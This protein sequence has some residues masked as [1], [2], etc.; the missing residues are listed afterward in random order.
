MTRDN[1]RQEKKK[2][3][4]AKKKK[5]IITSKVDA[6]CGSNAYTEEHAEQADAIIARPSATRLCVSHDVVVGAEAVRPG[7]AGCCACLS[8]WKET[9]RS[10]FRKKINVNFKLIF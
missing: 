3:K 1:F 2:K 10:A 5:A 9:M 6:E 7:H 8:K 4:K